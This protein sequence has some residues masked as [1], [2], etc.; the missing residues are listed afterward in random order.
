M[1][2]NPFNQVFC[3]NFLLI[4]IKSTLLKMGFNPF[5]QVFCSNKSQ[6]RKMASG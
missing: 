5:N 2:F 4:R 1:S 6:T 3:S